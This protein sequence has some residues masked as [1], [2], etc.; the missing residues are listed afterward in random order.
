[1]CENNVS[2]KWRLSIVS[3]LRRFLVVVTA[4]AR[5]QPLGILRFNFLLA[6]EQ[7]LDGALMLL[8]FVGIKCVLDCS[9]DDMQRHAA[10]FPTFDQGPI[11]RAKHEVLSAPAD[12]RVFD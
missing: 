4:D 11:D 3:I 2:R 1:M 8:R 12:E 10:L 5:F 7:S 6:V 9:Q